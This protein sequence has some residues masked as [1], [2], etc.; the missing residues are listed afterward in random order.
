MLEISTKGNNDIIDI[1]ALVQAEISKSRKKDG[2]CFLFVPHS[3]C[4]LTTIEFEPGV[5]GDLKQTMEELVPTKPDYQHNQAWGDGNAQ[6]HLRAA[7]VKPDLAVPF[8][9]GELQLGAWQQI[10]LIDFDV[11]PRQR[12]VIIKIKD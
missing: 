10:V 9:E 6:A 11:R 1:T 3:T 8:E 4:A 7:L 12:K 2:I 5:V